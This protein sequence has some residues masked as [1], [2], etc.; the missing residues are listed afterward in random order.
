MAASLTAGFGPSQ[1]ELL[2]VG[3]QFG[4]CML[5]VVM[6]QQGDNREINI[7][8]ERC[9]VWGTPGWLEGEVRSTSETGGVDD[10]QAWDRG[11]RGGGSWRSGRA[12]S[13]RG[14][15]QTSWAGRDWSWASW[16]AGARGATVLPECSHRPKTCTIPTD[17]VEPVEW[18]RQGGGSVRA[19]GAHGRQNPGEGEPGRLNQPRAAC[20]RRLQHMSK[21]ARPAEMVIVVAQADSE[22]NGEE[23][24]LDTRPPSSTSS[25]QGQ[26]RKP[27]SVRIDLPSRSSGGPHSTSS[28]S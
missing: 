16:S 21:S 23:P 5:Q 10:G 18:Q 22:G 7:S 14:S 8:G 12:S 15:C 3:T 2:W 26:K 13:G 20:E 9:D 19:S 1:R 28:S 27:A 6:R 25:H 24:R 17:G 11:G 4:D